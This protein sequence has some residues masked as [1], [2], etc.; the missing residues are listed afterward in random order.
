MY[1]SHCSLSFALS[2]RVGS[3]PRE[4]FG[5]WRYVMTI[6]M[7]SALKFNT[8]DCGRG[9][10]RTETFT[11]SPVFWSV[12]GVVIPSFSDVCS[13]ARRGISSRVHTGCTCTSYSYM[14]AIPTTAVCSGGSMHRNFLHISHYLHH[15]FSCIMYRT[16][17]CSLAIH[18]F[19]DNF[20]II[21][22]HHIFRCFS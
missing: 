7:R 9:T 12:C 2:S 14:S 6:R 19:I 15:V 17:G 10:K 4:S 3:T 11:C 18:F 16:S 21:R 8:S 20:T 22:S 1:I 5:Q 13:T